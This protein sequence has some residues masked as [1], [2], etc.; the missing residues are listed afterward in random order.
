MN[1]ERPRVKANQE[2]HERLSH[3][4]LAQHIEEELHTNIYEHR[5]S[6]EKFLLYFIGYGILGVALGGTLD[7]AIKKAQ[8]PTP[9]RLSCFGW[10][11][12]NL[13]ITATAFFVILKLKRGV[14][15]DDWMMAT[16]AGFIFSLCYFTSQSNLSSNMQCV[17]NG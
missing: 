12:G 5:E 9:K 10:L 4:Q 3:E 13:L 17:F 1:R 6:Y 8:G 14:K 7:Y 15:F 11:L 16:F 2:M